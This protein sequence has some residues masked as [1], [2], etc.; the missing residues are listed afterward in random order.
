MTKRHTSIQ[1]RP[2]GEL[3]RKS[4]GIQRSQAASDHPVMQLQRSLGNKAVGSVIGTGGLTASAPGAVQTKLTVGP[5]G[6]SYE[7]EADQVGRKVADFISGPS[8][9]AQQVQRD[10][11]E[12][13]I[14]EAEELQMKRSPEGI[15]RDEDESAVEE[16]EELQ[17]KRSPEGIQRDEDESAIEEAEELQMKRSP[18]GIQRDEDESAIE[19]TEELQMKRS[20]EG[21]QR[22]EDESAVEEAEELQM[23]RSGDGFDADASLERD[24]EQ[25]RGGGSPMDAHIQA[26]MESAFGT[27]FNQ[28]GIHTDGKADRMA[29]SIGASAFTTGS[30]IFF[31]QGQYNPGSRQGQELLGH[32]L[33]H[34]VQQRGGSTPT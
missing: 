29:R 19:E 18:E 2:E 15:Q 24:I 8:A 16:A 34:V 11:D 23:K 14:E 7:Q 5:A 30:D 6:D 27:K 25:K 1:K 3:S 20:P 31:R 26:K 33:T 13:A 12:S 28:V 9:G 4:K 10:E 21:I 22:N 17:M 32:E